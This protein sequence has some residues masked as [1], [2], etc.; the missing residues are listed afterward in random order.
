MV[1][2]LNGLLFSLFPEL[3][4]NKPS[5]TEEFNCEQ[6]KVQA[7]WL[8]HAVTHAQQ[9]EFS[10]LNQAKG[11]L[12]KIWETC[13]HFFCWLWCIE[14]SI[15]LEKVRLQFAMHLF[16]NEE[17]SLIDSLKSNPK[18]NV[19]DNSFTTALP[20]SIALKF[21]H[22]Y[23][24]TCHKEFAIPIQKEKLEGF[25]QC[26][27]YAEIIEYA[28]KCSAASR[29]ATLKK[30]SLELQKKIHH[31]K[32]EEC[33]YIPGGLVDYNQLHDTS[34]DVKTLLQKNSHLNTQH[35]LFEI[36]RNPGVKEGVI[37][38][39]YNHSDTID[40]LIQEENCLKTLFSSLQIS[41][42]LADTVKHTLNAPPYKTDYHLS[43]AEL[44][45]HLFT[46]LEVQA[47]P[48]QLYKMGWWHS[49]RYIRHLRSQLNLSK[50]QQG[51][52][53]H[54][55]E[56]VNPLIKDLSLVR[57]GEVFNQIRPCLQTPVPS[58]DARRIYPD[59]I[60][61][62]AIS[63]KKG[64]PPIKILEIFDKSSGDHFQKIR[65]L[66]EKTALFIEIFTS[67]E[68]KIQSHPVLRNWLSD[69]LMNLISSYHRYFGQD[70]QAAS[71]NFEATISYFQ[72]ILDKLGQAEENDP[73]L[74]PN[75]A[76]SGEAANQIANPQPFED[77]V[78]IEQHVVNPN[79]FQRL[80]SVS[81]VKRSVLAPIDF[82][83]R[84]YVKLTAEFT[85]WITQCQLLSNQKNLNELNYLL[86]DINQ[87]L[88][89]ADEK[90]FWLHLPLEEV[91]KWSA[92]FKSLSSFIAH[93]HHALKAA[94]PFPRQ[95]LYQLKLLERVQLLAKRNDQVTGFANFC[96]DTAAFQEILQDF[97]LDLEAEGPEIK[98]VLANLNQKESLPVKLTNPSKQHNQKDNDREFFNCYRTQ[99]P[100]QKNKNLEADFDELKGHLAPQVIHLR[101]MR[102]CIL[103][104]MERYRCFGK[105]TVQSIV[106]NG[107]K[108]SLSELTG[109]IKS[110]EF[111]PEYLRLRQLEI[112]HQL[113]QAKPAEHFQKN[114][115]FFAPLLNK[116]SSTQIKEYGL[117]F[118]DYDTAYFTQFGVE[119]PS[120]YKT[121]GYAVS[122][123]IQQQVLEA[124]VSNTSSLFCEDPT[125]KFIDEEGMHVD[126]NSLGHH[127]TGENLSEKEIYGT[128]FST[129]G[130][131]FD[132]EA[133]LKAMQTSPLATRIPNTLQFLLRHPLYF[134]G[135][136]GL[137]FQRLFHL[138]LFRNNA[139]ED[140]LR[141]RPYFGSI[142]VRQLTVAN[143][144]LECT[145]SYQGLLFMMTLMQQVTFIIQ[146]LPSLK[147]ATLMKEIAKE[148]VVLLEK[149]KNRC[150]HSADLKK[151]QKAI[152]ETYLL[153]YVYF[154]RNKF[155]NLAYD[156][157]ADKDLPLPKLL[158]LLKS[159]FISCRIHKPPGERNLSHEAKIAYMMHRLF[160]AYETLLADPKVCNRLIQELI[161]ATSS[162][163][164]EKP[165]KKEGDTLCFSNGIHSIDL[166]KGLVF[167][168]G[169]AESYLPDR[170]TQDPLFLDLFGIEEVHA[171]KC[172]QWGVIKEEELGQLYEFSYGQQEFR[173]VILG[174]DQHYFYKKIAL[175]DRAQ[176]SE[177]QKSN[178]YQLKQVES[179][180][181]LKT[182]LP[183]VAL[184]NQLKEDRVKIL[185]KIFTLHPTASLPQVIFE[186]YLWI[187]LDQLNFVIE[188]NRGEQLYKGLLY[189]KEENTHQSSFNTFTTDQLKYQTAEDAKEILNPWQE[190]NFQT[191]L[192]LD[193][194]S[195]IL[196]LGKKDQVEKISYQRIGLD[197]E[198][199]ASKQAWF[200][201][202]FNEYFLS[203]NKLNQ[204]IHLNF[205]NRVSFFEPHFHHYHLLEHPTKSPLLLLPVLE[206]KREDQFLKKFNRQI[207]PD[208]STSLCQ[209]YT[210]EIDSL[211]DLK[212]S[213]LESYFYLA[214][215]LFTQSRYDLAL[216]Y[217]KKVQNMRLKDN[218]ACY[219]ILEFFE[220]WNARGSQG[221]KR[222][223]EQ[224]FLLHVHLL[225][226]MQ[227][228]RL[229]NKAG[230]F[231]Q[232]FPLIQKVIA[233]LCQY[234][235][236]RQTGQLDPQLLIPDNQKQIICIYLTVIADQ[237]KESIQDKGEDLATS[238]KEFNLVEIY[239]SIQELKKCYELE[240]GSYD[241][242]SKL[243]KEIHYYK[244]K[245]AHP[246]LKK[247]TK[248][249][250]KLLSEPV[251]IFPAFEKYLKK[252]DKIKS[253][254][255]LENHVADLTDAIDQMNREKEN[256]A[257]ELANTLIQDIVVAA[258]LTNEEVTIL[259]PACELITLEQLL[260]E[261]EQAL[262]KQ[263]IASKKKILMHLLHKE[264]SLSHLEC[265]FQKMDSSFMTQEDT[266][267]KAIICCESQDWTDLIANG[268]VQASALVLLE[269]EI[270]NYLVLVTTSY[271]YQKALVCLGDYHTSQFK[272][273]L[274]RLGE[275]LATKRYYDPLTDPYRFSLLL[276]EQ[277]QR[278]IIRKD[279][280]EHYII[281]QKESNLFL[282]EPLAG[283][284]TT[285]LRNLDAH[286]HADG[287][288][289]A[290]IAT[291]EA[292]IG[293][294][295]ALLQ[296][297]SLAAYGKLVDRFEFNRESETTPIAL[298][299]IYRNFLKLIVERGRLDF[300]K[301]DML[302]FR[303]LILQKL[304]E[305]TNGSRRGEEERI[306]QEIDCCSDILQLIKNHVRVGTDEIDKI[307]S[308]TIEHNWGIGD[309]HSKLEAKK[310]KSA[311]L[312][313]KWTLEEPKYKRL[314][315]NGLYHKILIGKEKEN[316]FN[317]L[318][319]K[320]IEHYQLA[321]P[322]DDTT[323]QLATYYFTK[324]V[325]DSHK[326]SRYFKQVEEFYEKDIKLHSHAEELIYLH[327]F[328]Q[329]IL[330]QSLD[331]RNGVRFIRSTKDHMTV[332]PTTLNAVYNERSEHCSEEELIWFTCLNY[333]DISQQERGQGGVNEKQLAFLI[334]EAKNRAVE[335]IKSSISNDSQP[336]AYQATASAQRFFKEFHQQLNEITEKEYKHLVKE[337]N[338]SPKKLIKFVKSQVFPLIE[339]RGKKMMG[340]TQHF[341]NLFN[342]F[343]GS[344]GTSNSYRALPDKV[345][346]INECDKPYAKKPGVDGAVIRA[347]LKDYHESDLIIYDDSK[348]FA[349]QLS[350]LLLDNPGSMFIDLGANFPGFN[351]AEIAH[352]LAKLLPSSQ[353]R[354]I[355]EED[356][357]SVI[358]TST[359]QEKA[360]S[361]HMDLEKMWTIL[362]KDQERGT[363]LD[364]APHST[365]FFTL[366]H[367]TTLTEFQQAIMRLRKLGHG[368][369]ARL[370][371]DQEMNRQLKKP[372][373][374]HL[375]LQM[376]RNEAKS[377]Q[378]IHYKAERQKIMAIS[379]CYLYDALCKL[380]DPS[381]RIQVWKQCADF[382]EQDT[383]ERIVREEDKDKIGK[384]MTQISAL[385]ELKELASKEKK[386]IKKLAERLA[387]IHTASEELGIML[388]ATAQ[389]QEALE[390]R[391]IGLGLI[392]QRYLLPLVDSRYHPSAMQSQM[393]NEQEAT[394]DQ[395]QDQDQEQF[396]TIQTKTEI[397]PIFTPWQDLQVASVEELMT[398]IKNQTLRDQGLVM[399]LNQTLPFYAPNLFV[400][401][402]SFPVEEMRIFRMVIIVDQFAK[403]EQEQV[404]YLIGSSKDFDHIF[405]KI[406]KKF[407]GDGQYVYHLYNICTDTLEGFNDNWWDYSI[408]VQQKI[409]QAI[410]QVKHLAGEIFINKNTALLPDQQVIFK[411]W[412]QSLMGEFKLKDR[413]KT[414]KQY[415][416]TMRPSLY[417]YYK[418]S[419]M[420]KIYKQISTSYYN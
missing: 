400:T 56:S 395:E 273:H 34:L 94:G 228:Q 128:H 134:I 168:N 277:Q 234:N 107:V 231:E 319:K 105:R 372:K 97:Y 193:T 236:Y 295:H 369:R 154:F 368:Q 141:L 325:D 115:T 49:F 305:L 152:Q 287:R 414:L 73:Q 243:I 358:D 69:T 245:L 125:K 239:Q 161:P 330:P 393:Q 216:H 242:E 74:N 120:Q 323:I 402:N 311:L 322:N 38:R 123:P 110:G 147:D 89:L 192:S 391:E 45:Q 316:Y 361:N 213:C 212:S 244:Q 365:G 286:L 263:A 308:P 126:V 36:K 331:K 164:G 223:S 336:L 60:D 283:G 51:P 26:I 30:L 417:P 151:N 24:Q 258:E 104:M 215:V 175:K 347:F 146:S 257:T 15:D 8:S 131:S 418:G 246:P 296:T 342:Q 374:I 68:N 9:K 169:I 189:L 48:H 409:T 3:T 86:E 321:A 143:R 218:V 98:A 127:A 332:K 136:K 138:N 171:I 222:P 139:L 132:V 119:L 346:K 405:Y 252:A 420:Q 362:A 188:N 274:I 407:T 240:E 320:I 148:Q 159:Y 229:K 191:F 392:E 307:T 114:Q 162:L 207:K 180:P 194:P 399:P 37:F 256:Y 292:L 76:L 380:K 157:L 145:D 87:A 142:L 101:K 124:C 211:G 315:Q 337:I 386:R 237:M 153:S 11:K 415:L 404:T 291:D 359:L 419:P 173:I 109:K 303:H 28:A 371:I 381:L 29:A 241:E 227:Q 266:F 46:L 298:Q 137:M 112:D 267:R 290:G 156:P 265:L 12:Q 5:F 352:V 32:G 366:N 187:S 353:L 99:F 202:N 378:N 184:F 96:I 230:Q 58:L 384:P 379:E 116:D 349:P 327:K 390:K 383:Q 247:V 302:S 203:K 174:K 65:K 375:L 317:Y 260:K 221:S 182:S 17:D 300:T 394:K 196:A 334:A 33:L 373:I 177:L 90:K 360:F 282:Q 88:E 271:H 198:W 117:D 57:L 50:D 326:N 210:Y 226:F 297:T 232:T 301:R 140:F 160:P 150:E 278:V 293:Q 44:C 158:S 155:R 55:N 294:H 313:M 339:I 85:E 254:T 18:L 16:R 343:Y 268:T 27:K 255:L 10:H 31:L 356:K 167:E 329:I 355:K 40:S 272:I 335:E 275:I 208:F 264:K 135:P 310:C 367:Q 106:K 338:A 304:R 250:S 6:K 186:N 75:L 100:T 118:V 91:V 25:S 92:G 220:N 35:C 200:C 238:L 279:Q 382:F 64:A 363:H 398:K 401:V 20:F 280:L 14:P 62:H 61:S 351:A 79:A 166:I 249:F 204:F 43:Q 195:Y 259:D 190:K 59:G 2:S 219:S 233:G 102:M 95:I 261:Q 224:T 396:Q 345:V 385:E 235:H 312:L 70:F 178:W 364:M 269:Q 197:Y 42:E 199:Q 377:L 183:S 66:I 39:V 93:S 53:I 357:I 333:M 388:E 251:A 83:Q 103:G 217:L 63:L 21:Y 262:E 7:D 163:K 52:S 54:E 209:L 13:L 314:F 348:E 111:Y 214:Y 23:L 270:A 165:W 416:Y 80:T 389:A 185:E 201:K 340:N 354:F 410:V 306:H 387:S 370:L 129:L 403:N 144:L 81:I 281:N 122:A 181:S 149:W 324:K 170:L 130:Y 47:A 71:T 84:E 121:M 19:I 172:K 376:I 133:E 318:L 67:Y 289:L 205:K 1:N 411:E 82:D 108:T 288:H 72:T 397:T 328:L 408:P 77:L 248:L 22:Q 413:E 406:D 350:Q 285:L 276:L 78:V 299:I 284:K 41:T 253:N 113:S 225:L 206:F 344:S 341:V 4:N 412:V 309:K 176:K 179:C